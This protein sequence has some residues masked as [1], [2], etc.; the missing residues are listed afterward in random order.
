MLN[1]V[2]KLLDMKDAKASDFSVDEPLIQI[3]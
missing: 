1:E 3:L 2:I